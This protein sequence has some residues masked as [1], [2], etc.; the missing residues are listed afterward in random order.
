M[1]SLNFFDVFHYNDYL[2]PENILE[3]SGY[4]QFNIVFSTI[5]LQLR[6]KLEIC[7]RNL[8]SLGAGMDYGIKLKSNNCEVDYA[9]IFKKANHF[10]DYCNI[11]IF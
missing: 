2:E 5:P 1:K 4:M 9:L 10:P 8:Y 7:K 3:K 6:A 11:F